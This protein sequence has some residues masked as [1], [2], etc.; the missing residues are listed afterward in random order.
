M[1]CA[2]NSPLKCMDTF[3]LHI[4]LC[5]VCVSNPTG[6]QKSRLNPLKLKLQVLRAVVGAGLEPGSSKRAANPL[7]SRAIFPVPLALL[8]KN[9][10][11]KILT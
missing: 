8:K 5:I 2:F 4:C 11:S 10:F 1:R 3:H 6:G 7:H 9:N